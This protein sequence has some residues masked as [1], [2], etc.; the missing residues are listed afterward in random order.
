M[1]Y[2]LPTRKDNGIEKTVDKYK[3]ENMGLGYKHFRFFRERGV[4]TSAL[5][6]I[7]H[8]VWATIREWEELDDQEHGSPNQPKGEQ[9]ADKK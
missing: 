2:K 9:F 1:R 3:A 4:N 5:A 6:K 8:K 7:F